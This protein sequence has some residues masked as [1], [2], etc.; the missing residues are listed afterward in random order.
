M[1]DIGYSIAGYKVDGKLVDLPFKDLKLLCFWEVEDHLL[2]SQWVQDHHIVNPR[3][4][5]VTV[6]DTQKETVDAA[7]QYA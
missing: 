7:L 5:W 4:T 2:K 1:E 6:V 3:V